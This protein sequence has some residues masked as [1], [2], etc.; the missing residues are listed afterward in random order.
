VENDRDYAAKRSFD[1]TPEP[2]PEAE[3]DVDVATAPP[4]STFVIHQ[5]HARRLH[6]DLRLEMFNGPTPVLV[7][8]AVPKNLPLHK[9]QKTLAVK[10]ED[11]PFEYGS[12]SGSIPAG[13]YGAGE[14][15]IFDNGTYDLT[16][17]APGKLTI[18]LKGR[19]LQGTWHLIRTGREGKD[20]LA[21]LREWEG[22]AAEAPPLVKPMVPARTVEPFDD[23]DWAFE[24]QLD[25]ERAVLVWENRV[26]RLMSGELTEVTSDHPALAK[27]GE[28]LVA[29]NAIVDGFIVGTGKDEQLVA[30]DLLYLDGH[31]LAGEPYGRR[32]ELLEE[33]VVPGGVLVVSTAVPQAGKAV[34]ST[35][36]EHGV[37]GVI[38]KR[39]ASRYQSGP[40]EDWRTIGRPGEA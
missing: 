5:H 10:V 6:F 7:S 18:R 40:S 30:I 32:R 24:L 3:G 2:P 34:F 29:L 19:R 16:E 31:S 20:W 23:P 17:Q 22:E 21:M 33:A 35:A 13:N 9:G 28:R 39:L 4:G 37:G 26:T 38:A 36:V 1:Q 8:W 12:F 15:R 14:V 11:H 25:G 27:A